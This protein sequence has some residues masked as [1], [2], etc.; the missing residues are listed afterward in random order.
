M[1]DEWILF[2]ITDRMQSRNGD[3]EYFILR[4]FNTKT[5]IKAD[6]YITIG[7]RNNQWWGDIII[8]DI[9]G[10]YNFKKFKMSSRGNGKYNIID[11]D[12]IPNL[13]NQTTQQEAQFIIEVMK[14]NE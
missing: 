14:D 1:S 6:T 8:N 10:I 13:V 12:S 4:F 9:Y 7:Y 3:D 11:G 2:E 5:K